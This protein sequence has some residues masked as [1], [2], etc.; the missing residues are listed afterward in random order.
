MPNI[1]ST[2][3]AQGFSSAIMFFVQVYALR[4]GMLLHGIPFQSVYADLPAEVPTR[5]QALR[6]FA[7]ASHLI[8]GISVAVTQGAPVFLLRAMSCVAGL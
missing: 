6:R 8:V 3:I 5:R 2:A 1:I 7:S 4:S